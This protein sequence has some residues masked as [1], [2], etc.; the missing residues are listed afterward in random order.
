[1]TYYGTVTDNLKYKLE[2]QVNNVTTNRL[3]EIKEGTK[4]EVFG[5]INYKSIL[6]N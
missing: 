6:H 3:Q 5:E 2:I 1:M 4:I